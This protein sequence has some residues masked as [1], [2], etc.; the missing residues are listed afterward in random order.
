MLKLELQKQKITTMTITHTGRIKC[1]LMFSIVSMRFKFL[2]TRQL[3]TIFPEGSVDNNACRRTKVGRCISCA[4]G[5]RERQTFDYAMS[6]VVKPQTDKGIVAFG[7]C[8]VWSL[9][10]MV[11]SGFSLTFC[12]TR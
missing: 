2:L 7:I 4:S 5:Q 3:E 12:L 9:L 10:L 8:C 11:V 1:E 6:D